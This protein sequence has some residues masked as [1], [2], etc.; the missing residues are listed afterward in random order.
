[1]TFFTSGIGFVGV[2][3]WCPYFLTQVLDLLLPNREPLF[4]TDHPHTLLDLPTAY[5]S[6]HRRPDD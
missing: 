6:I 5:Q 2:V 3:T 4:W 1:M